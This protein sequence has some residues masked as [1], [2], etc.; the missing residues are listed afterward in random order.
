MTLLFPACHHMVVSFHN[1]PHSF[2]RL[3]QTNQDNRPQVQQHSFNLNTSERPVETSTKILPNKPEKEKSFEGHTLPLEPVD[4]LKYFKNLLTNFEQSEI[5]DYPEIWFLGQDA[6]KI[7]GVPGAENNN[8]YDD[9]QGTYIKVLH[10]HLA[11]RFEV[12]EVI[13]KGSF[14][15]VVKCLDHMNN[16]LVAIKIIRNK[17]RFHHQALVELKILELLRRRD[18]DGNHNIVR[19]KEYFYFRE[20]LCISFELLGLNLY[21]LIKKNNFQGFSLSLIRKFTTSILKCLQLLNKERIIHCDLKPENILLCKKGQVAIKVIDFGSSCYE[22][23]RVYTYVQ[24]RFYR[25]PEVILG[26]PYGLAIDMWSLGCI[27]AELYVGYPLFPGENE[28]DQLACIMEVLGLPPARFVQAA[29]RRKAFF[30][31]KGSPKSIMNS[32]G[33]KRHPNSK[34]LTLALQTSDATFLDFIKCCLRWNPEDRMTPNEAMQHG[35]IQNTKVLKLREKTNTA[36]QI[37]DAP[38]QSP[39]KKKNVMFSTVKAEETFADGA[40]KVKKEFKEKPA[41]NNAREPAKHV[42]ASAA[43]EPSE[44]T[45]EPTNIWTSQAK[46]NASLTNILIKKDQSGP[47][48]DTNLVNITKFLPPIL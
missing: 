34:D 24:S 48:D 5:L 40:E 25:S 16:E 2:K 23:Q 18:K 21:E 27:V 17:K 12:L 10:D 44:S 37:L 22:H 31:A 1:H 3:Y 9:D 29:P 47:S 33:R 14:G 41:K 4:T 45:S 26:Y 32:K 43:E 38:F 30:D 7:D 20:H 36:K 13:G 28:V 46:K 39:G 35:W 8:S 15:Q 6:I 11:Y 42:G 19:M